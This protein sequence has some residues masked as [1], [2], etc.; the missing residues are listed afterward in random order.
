MLWIIGFSIVYYGQTK[1]Y[2]VDESNTPIQIL[3][4][5]DANIHVDCNISNNNII[6][7]GNDPY[8]IFNNI[9]A[10]TKS[11]Q[12]EY[13][14]L[15]SKDDSRYINFNYNGKYKIDDCLNRFDNDSPNS[16]LFMTNDKNLQEI[17][18]NIISEA[19]I[20]KDIK[21]YGEEFVPKNIY[22]LPN[23]MW[24]IIISVVALFLSIIFIYL[25]NKYNFLSYLYTKI[26]TKINFS[27][28]KLILVIILLSISIVIEMFLSCFVFNMN[29]T[30]TFI[31]L[32]RLIFIAGTAIIIYMFVLICR[33]NKLTVEKIFLT[34]ALVMGTLMILSAP[35]GHTAPD[36]DSHLKWA[37]GPSNVNGYSTIAENNIVWGYDKWCEDT[38]LDN[39]NKI[40]Q[41]NNEDEVVSHFNSRQINIAHIPGTIVYALGR[42]LN[43]SFIIKIN[44]IRFTYLILYSFICYLS[45]KKLKSN[46][47]LLSCIALF[48]TNLFLA[49]SIAYDWWITAFTIYGT[50]TFLSEMQ[51]PKKK[52]AI[53]TTILI[54][55][56]IF[57]ACIVKMIYFPLLLLPLFLNKFDFKKKEMKTKHV[58]ITTLFIFA[59][60]ACFMFTTLH[61][62]NSVGDTRG[63]TDVNAHEQ[64]LF[65]LTNPINYA[66][67]L[68][69]FLISYLSIQTAIG[70]TSQ[71]GYF[72]VASDA[73]IFIILMILATII[74]RN[75]YDRYTTCTKI[76][77]PNILIFLLTICMI[78]TALYIIFTPVASDVISGCQ[79]R[80]IIPLL[81]PLLAT[82]G[83]H[84]IINKLSN[85]WMSL[86][87]FIPVCSFLLWDISSLMLVK[88]I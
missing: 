27:A 52:Y 29:S 4:C 20:L 41:L 65:I 81:F 3:N 61:T 10:R 78:P 66:Q 49:S 36:L 23:N 9:D 55:G 18:L 46:K 82:I 70:Y 69:N 43:L 6:I 33:H 30:N 38:L 34:I 47:Y 45:I 32:P 64:L 87:I 5:N 26:K 79:A 37:T 21:L 53:S 35:I 14:Y 12:F 68:F 59:A 11:I 63:G 77:F 2:E 13:Y 44:L 74:D 25:N 85:K 71:L 58:L 7:N 28:K 80:Y 76:K 60:I 57:I 51:Q 86:I 88:L 72:G 73:G 16:L 17:K 62:T 8:I 19:Y 39:Q 40:E 56:S 31:N 54:S 84:K 83:S 67:I 15:S 48:P 42:L 75:K 24:Y 50:A 22:L 1:T